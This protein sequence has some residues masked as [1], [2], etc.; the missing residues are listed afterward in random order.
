MTLDLFSRDQ[1]VVFRT[2]DY[3]GATKTSI[4]SASRLL[5]A[6]GKRG[7]LTSITRGVWANRNHPHFSPFA[8][9]AL[10]LTNETGYVSFLTALHHH[11]M[12]SQIPRTIQVAGTGHGRVVTTPVATYEFF[13]MKP[14]FM[15]KGIEWSDAKLPFLMATPEKALIDTLYIATRKTRRFSSLPEIEFV[16]PFSRKKFETLLREHRFPVRIENAIRNRFH[17]L[18]Q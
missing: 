3:A 17:A 7:E 14:E 2:R 11:G 13:Q 8:C 6:M 1:Y 10:L 9:V 4:A 15:A 12:L 16:K 5:N 18:N